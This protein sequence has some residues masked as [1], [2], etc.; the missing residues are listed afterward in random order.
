MTTRYQHFNIQL[1]SAV[2]GAAII[3]A[4]GVAMVCNMRPRRPILAFLRAVTLIFGLPTRC[5]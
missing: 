1:K 3:A 2:L 4:G 5:S